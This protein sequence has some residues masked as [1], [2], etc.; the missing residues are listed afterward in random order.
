MFLEGGGMMNYFT[1]TFAGIFS[2]EYRISK[3]GKSFFLLF[4]DIFTGI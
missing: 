3:D 2:L 1:D 4:T